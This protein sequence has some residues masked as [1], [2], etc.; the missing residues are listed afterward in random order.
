MVNYDFRL[1]NQRAIISEYLK[2]NH[3]HPS[4]EEIFKHVKNKLPRISKK[5][6]YST[7]HFL[8]DEGLIQEVEVKGVQRYEPRSDPHHHV[9]CR[10]CGKIIDIESEELSSHAL[11]VG[12][13]IGDF[14]VE[15]SN[16]H[17]Y[18][19]CKECKEAERNERRS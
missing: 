12:K 17:F 11:R 4:V 6:V 10:A 3:D 5:T 18:G 1:T 19:M 9:I 14:D 2:E 13:Q 15:S 7:L 8:C 16:V